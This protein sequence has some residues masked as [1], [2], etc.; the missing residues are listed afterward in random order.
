MADIVEACS[1]DGTDRDEMI[2]GDAAIGRN[3]KAD[4]SAGTRS[5]A[6]RMSQRRAW[7]L[8]SAIILACGFWLSA[9]S[10][11][12]HADPA[13][14]TEADD[15][16]AAGALAKERKVPVLLFFNRVGCPYC[17]RALR[18]FLVPMEKDPSNAGRVVFR[19][20]EINKQDKMVDFKGD[21]TTHR[22]FAQ[23]Y[24][25]RLTPTIWF[26]DGDGNPLAEAII[27][28]R[29]PDYYGYYLEQAIDESLKKIRQQ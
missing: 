9:A 19:Q 25:I 23:R 5:T 24:K 6:V 14:L 21:V 15:L 2:E 7:L 29:T 4:L 22:K 16:A 13:A 20:V 11:S 8:A 3:R 27:G 18:E 1:S 26:V 10:N 17:E 12:A 28:L